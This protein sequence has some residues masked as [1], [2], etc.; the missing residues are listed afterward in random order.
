MF[1][2]AKVAETADTDVSVPVPYPV[3]IY[4]WLTA[5]SAKCETN[6]I[7]NKLIG[8]FLESLYITMRL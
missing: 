1:L 6:K 2:H 3:Y 7:A 4:P 5:F 8:L